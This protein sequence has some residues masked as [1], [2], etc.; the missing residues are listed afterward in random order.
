MIKKQ[1]WRSGNVLMAWHGNKYDNIKPENGVAISSMAAWRHQHGGH[2][3]SVSSKKSG[4]VTA[5]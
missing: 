1:A 4:I 2:Q 3:R 5:A